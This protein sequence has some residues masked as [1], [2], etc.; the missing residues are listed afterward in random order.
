MDVNN[1]FLN[2]TLSEDVFMNQPVGFEDRN[3]PDY[4]YKMNKSLYGLRQA[5]RAWFDRFKE[6]LLNWGFKNSKVDSSLFYFRNASEIMLV[7]IYVSDIIIIGN[8]STR[9][10][11]F[12]R[13][14][15][16]IF[17]LKDLNELNYF[18]GIKV[19]RDETGM[20]L[21]QGKYNS[22]LLKRYK[23][24]HLKTCPTPM[25]TGKTLSITDGKLLESPSEYR[26]ELQYLTHTRPDINFVVNIL[27]QFLK[28]PTDAH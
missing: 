28:A 22:E 7:L 20:Y 15:N 6:T 2:G 24:V 1:A 12:T 14:L 11:E 13:K 27:S 8:I 9:L 17:A 18:L 21:S 10:K 5:P 23:M 4:V 26:S 25:T 3:H 19:Y 16:Q